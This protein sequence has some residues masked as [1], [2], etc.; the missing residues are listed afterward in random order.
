[1]EQLGTDFDTVY[2]VDVSPD[3]QWLA[4]IERRE[5]WPNELTILST[6]TG[7]ASHRHINLRGHTAFVRFS[8]NA[9]KLLL[10]DNGEALSNTIVR[11]GQFYLLDTSSMQMRHL[12][13]MALPGA[14]AWLSEESFLVGSANELWRWNIATG[15]TV[16]IWRTHE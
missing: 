13:D 2:G 4:V 12:G 16:K 3:G 15:E 10:W 5:T 9:K 7:V 14:V 11:R 1:L 8:P 6:G